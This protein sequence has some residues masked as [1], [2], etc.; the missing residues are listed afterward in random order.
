VNGIYGCAGFVNGIFGCAGWANGIYGCAGFVNGIIGC[1]G[2]ENGIY[3]CAGFVNDRCDCAWFL[4]RLCDFAGCVN[5]TKVA[6]TLNFVAHITKFTES[7][8]WSLKI[9]SKTSVNKNCYTFL[10]T[11]LQG[12]K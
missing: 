5:T 2:L 7:S 12:F 3:D 11:S 8:S 10:P 4:I 9:F 6:K 1:A